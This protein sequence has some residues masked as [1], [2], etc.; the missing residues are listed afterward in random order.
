MSVK[1][2]INF[3]EFLLSV[4]EVSAQTLHGEEYSPKFS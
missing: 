2:A 4:S 3:S 1:K